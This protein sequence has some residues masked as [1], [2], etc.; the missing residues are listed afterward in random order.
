MEI[1]NTKNLRT[2]S[3]DILVYGKAGTGKTSLVKTLTDPKRV[4]V[5]DLEKGL[6]PLTEAGVDFVNCNVGKDGEL[7]KNR[8]RF[9]KFQDSLNSIL[10]SKEYRKKYD[11]VVI[12]SVTALSTFCLAWVEE[13]VKKPQYLTKNKTVDE[14][15]KWPMYKGKMLQIIED[16][17]YSNYNVLYTCLE[18]EDVDKDDRPVFARPAMQGNKFSSEAAGVFSNIFQLYVNFDE[19]RVL[20]TSGTISFTAKDRSNKLNKIEPPNLNLIHKKMITGSERVEAIKKIFK[21]PAK[22]A[23]EEIKQDKKLEVPKKVR[24]EAPV[25]LE[26]VSKM[27]KAIQKLD[28]TDQEKEKFTFE[29]DPANVTEEDMV[30]FQNTWKQV[31]NERKQQELPI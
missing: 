28:M 13:E 31:T 11:W 19:T 15:K 9:M 25:A 14:F 3:V 7:M 6:T 2:E 26:R 1:Q 24:N 17:K 16:L 30:K 21:E 18:F 20:K 23:V 12:D 22:T 5:L 4:I 27:T 29:F 8:F 10:D